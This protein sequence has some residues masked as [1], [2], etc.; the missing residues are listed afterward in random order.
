MIP[1]DVL[2]ERLGVVFKIKFSYDMAACSGIH[3]SF[4][5]LD[6]H[7]HINEVKELEIGVKWGKKG[8]NGN[9]GRNV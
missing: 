7:W 1:S 3:V 8:H 4:I 6:T 2:R 9:F 5:P